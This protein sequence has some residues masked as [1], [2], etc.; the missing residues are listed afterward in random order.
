MLTACQSLV[1]TKLCTFRV[2]SYDDH[3]RPSDLALVAQTRMDLASGRAREARKAAGVTAAEFAAVCGVTAAT[4]SY[5]E[6]GK[7]VPRTV[8]ALA[9]GRLLA[10][11]ARQAA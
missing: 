6:T 10:T 8:H 11:L 1:V 4:V 5:W 7:R 3:V 2:R 9:Y